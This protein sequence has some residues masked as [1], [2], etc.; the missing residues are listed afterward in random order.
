MYNRPSFR[1]GLGA[2]RQSHNKNAC[3]QVRFLSILVE[4]PDT[5]CFQR[6]MLDSDRERSGVAEQPDGSVGTGR[7][8]SRSRQSLN[9]LLLV[10]RL[11]QFMLRDNQLH[12]LDTDEESHEQALPTQVVHTLSNLPSWKDEPDLQCHCLTVSKKRS[13]GATLDLTMLLPALD[14]VAV[15]I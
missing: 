15:D 6:K 13:P 10:N 4:L 14:P 11:L 7:T 1:R 2:A 12:S 9:D 3:S 8:A 5:D